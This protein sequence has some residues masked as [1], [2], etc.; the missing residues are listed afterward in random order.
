MIKTLLYR[1]PGFKI[2]PV[3][4]GRPTQLSLYP[5]EKTRGVE[6]ACSY[7]SVCGPGSANAA[8][9]RSDL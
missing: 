1:V 9:L 4:L 5:L 2:E 6:P 3:A 7:M 8:F